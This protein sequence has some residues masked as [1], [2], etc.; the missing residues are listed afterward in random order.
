MKHSAIL[1]RVEKAISPE[2]RIVDVSRVGKINVTKDDFDII[3]G[4]KT[5]SGE[6]GIIE[7][8]LMVPI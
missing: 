8:R 6:Y 4:E 3:P 5:I 7:L 1:S 2:F